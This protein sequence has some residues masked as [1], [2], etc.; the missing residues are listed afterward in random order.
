MKSISA[1]ARRVLQS[2]YRQVMAD[3]GLAPSETMP[4]ADADRPSAVATVAPLREAAGATVDADDA[5]WKRLTGR[6]DKDLDPLTQARANKLAL[7][8]WQSNP[9]ANRL[10][11]LPVAYLL[12]K[13]VKLKAADA[14]PHKA[15]ATHK[16]G[17][18]LLTE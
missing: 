17:P 14:D 5:S 15:V 4:A 16:R 9:L 1:S 12:G 18:A 2:A 3:A 13:G 6:T 7:H 10:I 11:E 8:V